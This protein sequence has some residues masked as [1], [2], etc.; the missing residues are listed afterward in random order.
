MEN[1]L[2][3]PPWSE[4]A[5][6]PG[7]FEYQPKEG[8]NIGMTNQ[9]RKLVIRDYIPADLYMPEDVVAVDILY[10]ET[11]NPTVYSVRTIT[12]ED[13]GKLWPIVEGYYYDNERTWRVC[14]RN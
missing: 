11:N 5:F 4:I 2:H 9:I 6:L 8:Y 14:F 13:G 10:K 1:T 7:R 12:P 3:L